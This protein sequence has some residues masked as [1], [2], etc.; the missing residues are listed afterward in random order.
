MAEG[1]DVQWV[2]VTEGQDGQ[3]VDNF[4]MT[5][6]KGAPRA[7]I[8]RIVRKGEVRVNGPSAFHVILA[9]DAVWC[10]ALSTE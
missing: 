3:R 2:E 4:L 1:R 6:I 9:R 8:Y 10:F 5:R 7:L